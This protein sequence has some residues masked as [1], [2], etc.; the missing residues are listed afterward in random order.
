MGFI[1]RQ[2]DSRVWLRNGVE[3]REPDT[4]TVSEIAIED[5]DGE[6][7]KKIKDT[8]R[9]KELL[10]AYENGTGFFGRKK[11]RIGNCIPWHFA[12]RSIPF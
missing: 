4:G 11:W 10:D 5:K 2:M 8:D 3:L 6:I 7:L 1:F 9:I 12:M